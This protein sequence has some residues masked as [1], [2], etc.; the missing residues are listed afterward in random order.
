MGLELVLVSVCV[1]I[2]ARART[3]VSQG[4]LLPQKRARPPTPFPPHDKKHVLG[5]QPADARA[6]SW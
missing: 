2:K 3:L 1:Q 4:L 6:W 5:G